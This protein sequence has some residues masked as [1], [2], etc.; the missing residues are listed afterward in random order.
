MPKADNDIETAINTAYGLQ[1]Q[2]LY[3]QLATGLTDAPAT[4][5]AEQ[6]CVASFAKGLEI[7]TRARDLALGVTATT[8][9]NA[10]AERAP[11]RRIA[12]ASA[13]KPRTRGTRLA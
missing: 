11:P 9:N 12:A 6:D 10:V 5:R 1:I 3:K 7:A 8:S 13:A 2:L 4:H